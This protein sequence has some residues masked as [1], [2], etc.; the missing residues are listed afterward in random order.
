[1]A[2]LK[3]VCHCGGV[4]GVFEVSGAQAPLPVQRLL[5]AALEDSL[6]LA[7][8]ESRY[9]TLSTS[10]TITMSTCILP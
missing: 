4:L 10:T 5:L 8:F 3:E 1:M 6:L 7:A 2:L 9:R